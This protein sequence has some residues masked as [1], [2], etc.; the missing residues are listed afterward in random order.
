MY[1]SAKT[2]FQNTPS[3][4]WTIDHTFLGVPLCDALIPDGNGGL[5]KILPA[6]VVH[7]SD[8]RLVISFTAPFSGQARLVGRTQ[9]P[10]VFT[11]GS[12]DPGQSV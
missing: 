1:S 5:A 4:T 12:V 2:H 3:A 11:A 7:V 9:S 10:L 8:T 6:S